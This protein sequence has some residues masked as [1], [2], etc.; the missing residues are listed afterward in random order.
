MGDMVE[1]LGPNGKYILTI[2]LVLALVG[3][4]AW[5]LR[6]FGAARRAL[7]GSSRNRQP[8]LA[9]LDHATVDARRKLVLI[10]R[11]NVEHLLLI[12]GPT[13][14]V[15]EMNIVRATPVAP[16]AR[17]A[18]ADE[19]GSEAPLAPVA[20]PETDRSRPEPKMPRVERNDP[21][22]LEMQKKLEAAM[23]KPAE[24]EAPTPKVEPRPAA[25]VAPVEPRLTTPPVAPEP[26]MVAAPAPEPIAAPRYAEPRAAAPQPAPE[27]AA[28]P[29][30]SDPFVSLEEEM[31]SLLRPGARPQ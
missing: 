17:T 31:A 23:T 11:D 12:G 9:V 7:S 19:T 15:V 22:Y 30:G 24:T 16:L 8:R 10:R 13:D 27:V 25:A 20:E 29:R 21:Q 18:R 3:L 5:L 2:L 28:K 1:T 26:K 14:V 4:V 6:Q